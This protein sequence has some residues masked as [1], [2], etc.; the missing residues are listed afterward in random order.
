MIRMIRQI[1]IEMCRRTQILLYIL[2]QRN[3]LMTCRSSRV[4]SYGW[5]DDINNH[6]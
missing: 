6:V 1:Y 2:P 5:N 3:S 4:R